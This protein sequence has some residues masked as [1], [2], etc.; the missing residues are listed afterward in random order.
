MNPGYKQTEVGVIP[1][2]WETRQLGEIAETSSGTTPLRALHERY[3]RMGSHAWVKTLDLND[4]ILRDTDER[5]TD[6]ALK[7]T[8]LRL[9]PAGTVLVAMY[10]GYNQIGRTGLLSLSAAVNQALTAIQPS[11]NLLESRFLLYVLNFRVAHWKA[12]ASSSRK[13]PNITSNDV[14]AFVVSR[15]PIQE[16]RAIAEALSDVDGLIGALDALIAKKRDL[17][18]AA[19]QQL[20][21][22]QTRLPGFS[23]DWE[24]VSLGELFT[25]K[26][27][28]N[29]GKEFFGHGTPIVNYMDV[30]RN[31]VI[32]AAQLQG[33][34]SLTSQET[35]NFD[36]KKGDVFFTRTSETAEE[37]GIASVMLDE[38][39]ETVFSGFVLRGRPKN[40]RLRDEFK[41]YCFRSASVRKQIISKASYTT[42]ALTNGRIL[43]AIVLP[44]PPLPE[45][46][47]I[48]TLLSDMDAELAAL[49][50]RRALEACN[51][52]L[53][54][55]RELKP[56]ED[57]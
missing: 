22:A 29:K 11:A 13:D 54:A 50:A 4:S 10:G 16:Q 37:I 47:A 43:S 40:D 35:K 57:K 28:L 18:Q 45:Q 25:F 31:P 12:V 21:T 9:Y 14:R 3:Y 42:R 48:A 7:E 6:L 19:M 56:P 53:K 36:V 26:N 20:L 52:Q 51:A 39:K 49:E 44:V 33:R 55:L 8:S 38:P 24:R 41:A 15:P 32:R 1:E 2:D 34:V 5:V 46:T 23:V 30:F 17:K 27:G